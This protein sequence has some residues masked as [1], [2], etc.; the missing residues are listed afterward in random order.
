MSSSEIGCDRGGDAEGLMMGVVVV[1]TG[2][3]RPTAEDE[4]SRGEPSRQS[5]PSQSSPAVLALKVASCEQQNV[6][7]QWWLR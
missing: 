3:P 4:L 6:K 5:C 7:L 2:L 1:V